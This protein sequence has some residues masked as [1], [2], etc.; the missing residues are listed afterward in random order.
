VAQ[1][2]VNTLG[3]LFNT[4]KGHVTELYSAVAATQAQ[5][6]RAG[7]Q[8]IDQALGTA[9]STGYLPDATS[10]SDAITAA[11]SGLDSSQFGS[12]FEQQRAQLTL[13]GKL[14]ELKDLT[15]TQK[16]LAE[17]QLAT[18]EDQLASLDKILSNAKDQVDALRGIDTSVLSVGQALEKI[19]SALLGEKDGNA[20]ATKPGVQVTDPGAQF[21]VGGGGSGTGPATGGA[22]SGGSSGGFTVG[23]GGSGTSSSSTKYSREVNLGAGA[24]SVGVTDPAEISRLDSLATL[25]QKFTGTGNVKGLLEATQASGATLSDLATMAG[26]R[27][28]DLLK[29]AESVGVPRFAVGTNYVPQDMLALIHEGEAI[30]PKAYNPAAHALPQASSASSELLT[31]LIAEVQ[32]LRAQTAQLEAQAR[33]TADATNGNPE[34]GAVPMALVEDH[35]Q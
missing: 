20:S 16:T 18:A 6:A 30:V 13:A 17:Q 3:S 2:S 29:A 5:S 33:R 25:A 12:A 8:F 22:S 21:T 34:G 27:Y 1:E 28:E 26:F 24:F 31:R 9:R 14:A 4:L 32:A 15:G 23:G 11:R 10:L 19:S 7:L 35:T